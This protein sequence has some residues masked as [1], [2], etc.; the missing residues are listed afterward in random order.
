MTRRQMLALALAAAGKPAR[1]QYGG[2]ASRGVKPVPRGKPSGRPFPARFVNV[3]RE[4]GLHAPVIYGV[5]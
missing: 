2:M 3:A 5:H 1:A 4:A